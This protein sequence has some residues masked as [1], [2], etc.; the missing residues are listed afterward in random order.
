MGQV[1]FTAISSNR[2]CPHGLH[3][4]Q[5]SVPD[6]VL[7]VRCPSVQWLGSGAKVPS[8][9]PPLYQGSGHLS[10]CGSAKHL[11]GLTPLC[12]ADRRDEPYLYRVTGVHAGQGSSAGGRLLLSRGVTPP[13]PPPTVVSRSNT[14]PDQGTP[15][16]SVAF[17]TSEC[18]SCRP[19]T[20]V[21]QVGRDQKGA[22]S[23]CVRHGDATC[24]CRVVAATAADITE[25]HMVHEADS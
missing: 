12:L 20:R 18:V 24:S 14:S 17:Q 23:Y 21:C 3:C 6:H 19:G 16:K 25:W 10:G 11:A 1:S 7:C 9:L 5:F 22:G 8:S 2:A 4:S 13:P 15:T